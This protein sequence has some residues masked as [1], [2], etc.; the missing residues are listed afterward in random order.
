MDEVT[1]KP[2][3]SLLSP[4]ACG[5]SCRFSLPSPRLREKQETITPLTVSTNRFEAATFIN[6]VSQWKHI[7]SDRIIL[8][9]IQGATIEFIDDVLP[10][11]EKPL[12]STVSNYI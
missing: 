1:N 6:Q 11:Q 2:A 7:T 9:L 3:W 5:L 4:P 12:V 8:K 10:K